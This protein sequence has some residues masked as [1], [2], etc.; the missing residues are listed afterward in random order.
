MQQLAPAGAIWVTEPTY[1]A[2][3]EAFAWQALGPMAVKGKA[4]DLPVYA[5][6]GLHQVRSRFEV[7]VQRGLTQFVGRYPELQRLLAALMQAERVEGQVVSVVGEAGIGKSRLLHGQTQAGE[8]VQAYLP[9]DL[10]WCQ[11]NVYGV[12][13]HGLFE[14]A[15]YRQ[16]FLERLGWRGQTTDEWPAVIDASLNQVAGLIVES[17]WAI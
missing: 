15:P 5:L 9:D 6:L 12:Y 14:S 7:V 2:A 13:V 1:R 4:D 10:G 16:Q 3:G 11:D 8:G 17:G